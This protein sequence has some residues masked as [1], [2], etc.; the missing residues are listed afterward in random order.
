MSV[1]V[2]R[3]TGVALE[4]ELRDLKRDFV[5]E[6]EYRKGTEEEIRRLQAKLRSDLSEQNLAHLQAA[7]QARQHAKRRNS[8]P[9]ILSD[10]SA[11][12]GRGGV[13]LRVVGEIPTPGGRTATGAFGGR[14]SL[15]EFHVWQQRL[16]RVRR[17][18]ERAD[19]EQC[20]QEK[21]GHEEYQSEAARRHR[22]NARADFK[23][24]KDAGLQA[25]AF[26]PDRHLWR[27]LQEA[28]RNLG[29]GW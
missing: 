10:Y 7:R 9:T 5:R 17:E 18:E 1:P 22:D 11:P 8:D 16:E 20:D 2:S 25:F 27:E 14:N 6:R 15:K 19:R 26:G 12:R 24:N 21:I 28:E 13:L 23:G 3:M 29:V 4:N